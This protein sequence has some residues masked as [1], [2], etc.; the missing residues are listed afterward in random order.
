MR[1]TFPQIKNIINLLTGSG[2]TEKQ[3]RDI[4]NNSDDNIIQSLLLGDLSSLKIPA[5]DLRAINENKVIH[6]TA[7]AVG[8]SAAPVAL[9]NNSSDIIPAYKTDDVIQ[10]ALPADTMPYIKELLRD[11][12]IEHKYDDPHK[13]PGRV[14]RGFCLRVGNWFKSTRLL[15][16][17]VKL[18][19]HG[20]DVAYIPE[21]ILQTFD[22]WQA[23]TTE[24]DKTPLPSDFAAFA[25]VSTEY[26]NENRQDLSSARIALNKKLSDCMQSGLLAHGVDGRYNSV[27]DIFLLKSKF[28]YIETSQVVHTSAAASVGAGDLPMLGENSSV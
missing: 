22:I 27:F 12:C 1:L 2:Y 6:N 23:L 15:F 9:S 19:T 8:V 17:E 21:L 25:G 11:F 18:K 7:P 14:W 3:A 26:L 13:I 24:Y 16:D 20:G 28:G 10:P 5:D 4:I